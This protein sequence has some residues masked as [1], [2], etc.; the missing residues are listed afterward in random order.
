MAKFFIERPIF[1]I[2]LSLI[3]TIAGLLAAVQLPV[4][5]Y[6]NI[7]PPTVS[8][9]ATYQGANADVID[10]SV[11]QIVEDKVNGAEGMVYMSSTSSDAGSYSLNIQFESGKNSDMA[12]VQTQSRVSEATPALPSSVQD[13]GVSTRK[14][15]QDTAMVFTLWSE[16]NQYDIKFLKNYGSIYIV[17]ELKRISGV[18]DIMAFGSDYSMR[19]WLQPEKMARLGISTSEI[20]SAI[21]N[22]NQQAASGSLGQMPIAG[23]QDYQYTT[24]V[25]GRLDDPKEFENIVV[26]SQTDGSFVRLKDVARIELGSKD[27]SYSSELNGHPASGF[28]VKLTSDANALQTVGEVKAT[29]DRLAKDFPAG[30]KY[31]TV[32]DNT[33]FVDESI[34]EVAK[35]FAEAMF[36]VVLVVFLFLQSWRAT[37]IPV[38]AIPVSLIGTFGAF[39][40]MGFTINTLTLFAMVLAI[41]LVVDDAIVVIEAVEHHMRYKGLSPIDATKLAM[42]EVSGPV[43]A[44]AF[45]L[46]SVFIPVAFFG[47]MMG[48]LYRQFALT[49]AVSMALSAIVA[50]SLTPALC[51]LLLKPH[52]PDA[53]QGWLGRFFEKFNGWLEKKTDGYGKR[54]GW[55]IPRGRLC[56]MLLVGIVG[57]LSVL[58]TLVPSSFVPDED[59]GRYMISVALPESTSLNRT[60]Q[61]MKEVSATIGK[62]SGVD[63]VMAISGFDL[64]GGSAKANGG[65]IFVSLS[66]WSERTS[67]QTQVKSLVKQAFASGAQMAEGRVIPF[68]PPSLPGLGSVGG[69]TFM[70]EDRSGGTL[71]KLD[72]VTQQFI[73]AAKER[74][75]IASVTTTFT[76]ETPGYE[77]E[78]DRE[79]AEKL[80]VNVDDI[81]STLQVF[82]GGLQVNDFNKFGRSYKVIAQAEAPFRGD[83]DALRYLFVKNSSNTMVP[84]NTL[85][86]PKK[87]KAA[88]NISRYNGYKAV[89][90]NGTQ[91]AGYSS[92]Q[93]MT[94]LEEVAKEVLPSGYTYEWSGQSRE[95]KVSGG[96]APIVFGL[97]IV[98][99]FLCLAALYESWS[100]PFAVLLSVPTGIFGAFL[101]Q[102]IFSQENNIYMQIGLVMLI[103]L[104]AKNAILIVEFAKVR[105]DKGMPLMDAAIE[106]AKLRLRPILMTSFAFIIGCLPLAIATGAGAGSRNSMGTAVVGGMF[107]ATALGIFLIPVLFV[108]VEKLTARFNN[109][110]SRF[111]KS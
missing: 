79:K 111:L 33:R 48:I 88:A 34:V 36:L 106:A 73:A 67:D 65:T 62:Q 42:Q 81:F 12:S 90:I 55:M 95:E 58:F 19:I 17:D 89:K 82:L 23:K 31:T 18:G 40:L 69:Y 1:A 98:F 20:K 86:T 30:M 96:R 70:L 74:P 27:Y 83:V 94:A 8:V 21:Q 4:A 47:G 41:G 110:R 75:E 50:L 84:L 35:T 101:F 6:P 45:V 100:V 91:A 72:S 2:V 99:V 64:M 13:L 51:T 10:Q 61:F 56:I 78:V 52:D 60:E 44:I 15:S 43:V 102:Y 68:A 109:W 3:I 39:V 25:K 105:F 87:T 11:A 66:P 7:S 28:A 29:L 38:L 59:Q 93:A 71:E 85:V 5:Q 24:R 76:T 16:N 63:N 54:L 22:Q 92:G 49:I 107:M 80:G 57:M 97:A 32:V 37:L 108:V 14:A 53:H 9:S 103:G 46:A 77:F 104:A 26:R